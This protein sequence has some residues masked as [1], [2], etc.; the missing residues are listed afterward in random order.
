MIFVNEF[1]VRKKES[2]RLLTMDLIFCPEDRLWC[3]K[4]HSKLCFECLITV[5]CASKQLALAEGWKK[6][7]KSAFFDIN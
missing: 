6:L 5:F 4:E 1:L 2:L 7:P 3:S